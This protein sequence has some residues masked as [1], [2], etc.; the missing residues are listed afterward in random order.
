MGILPKSQEMILEVGRGGKCD[1]Y[2]PNESDTEIRCVPSFGLRGHSLSCSLIDGNK[3]LEGR[4]SIVIFSSMYSLRTNS[5]RYD[6]ILYCTV[7]AQ[8]CKPEYQ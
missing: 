5:R 1:K 8:L 4:F 6:L 3:S 2:W 7:M